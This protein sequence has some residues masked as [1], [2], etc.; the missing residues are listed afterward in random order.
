MKKRNQ[1]N[2]RVMREREKERSKNKY[3][4]KNLQYDLQELYI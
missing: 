3:I 1:G 2:N 4:K